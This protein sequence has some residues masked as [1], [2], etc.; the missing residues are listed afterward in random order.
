MKLAIKILTIATL[1]TVMLARTHDAEASVVIAGTRV[2][3]NQSDSEVTVKLTNNGKLP[4]LVK[5]WI[6]NGNPDT[7]PDTIEVPFAITPSIMRIDPDKSQTLR[8]MSSGEPLPADRESILYLNVLEVPPK[9]TGDEADANQLQLAFRSRIKFF[10]RPSALKGQPDSA[11]G[12]VVW[13]IKP[14][15]AA[16]K[17]AAFNP[18]QYF[19]SFDRITLTDGARTAVFDEGGMVGPGETR[20]FALTSDILGPGAKLHYTAIND[21]GGPQEGEADLQP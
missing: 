15:D 2:I 14:G 1:G 10:Y 5:V 8:I 13:Q 18:S 9:P 20:V 6:D 11:S 3:Y 16:N 4:G 21:Y 7:A 17:I 19:V 12:Q